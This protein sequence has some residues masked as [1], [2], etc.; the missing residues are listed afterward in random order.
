M[1]LNKNSFLFTLLL[2]QSLT[3]KGALEN[4]KKFLITQVED[5]KKW[6]DLPGG[7]YT[8]GFIENKE[9]KELTPA[10]IY[11]KTFI[12][13]HSIQFWIRLLA[14]TVGI[15]DLNAANSIKEIK[16]KKKKKKEI[17]LS[18]DWWK[19]PNI[20]WQS[21]DG[22]CPYKEAPHKVSL[23][24]IISLPKNIDVI[25]KHNKDI[26][27]YLKIKNLSKKIP[28]F[29]EDHIFLKK[30]YL[31]QD[32]DGSYLLK[33]YT[34]KKEKPV[35]V[36]DL[37]AYDS[38]LHYAM[39]WAISTNVLKASLSFIPIFGMTQVIIAILERAFNFIETLYLMRHA[40]TLELI[41]QALSDN[42]SSP[43]YNKLNKEEMIRAITYL[44]RSNSMLS[45][46]IL[47]KLNKKDLVNKFLE[48][49]EK[50][51]AKSI[52]YLNSKKIS[53]TPLKGTGFALGIKN[54]PNKKTAATSIK[55]KFKM[56]SLTKLQGLRKKPYSLV[57]YLNTNKEIRKRNA[58]EAGLIG[59]SLLFLPIP[60]LQSIIKISY[61]EGIIRKIHK[62]Q[63]QEE[64]L[65]A[66]ILNDPSV[67]KDLFSKQGFNEAETTYY[68]EKTLQQLE[69]RKM[70]P[71][72]LSF[73]EEHKNRRKVERWIMSKDPSY[74]P[75]KNSNI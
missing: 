1:P 39:N 44:L 68:Y 69:R 74:I 72:D 61:K 46:I 37:L 49:R 42:K 66:T 53:V 11:D 43:F 9:T 67:F 20:K 16:K 25:N 73:E 26:H 5:I 22:L 51:Y 50:S 45:G 10:A 28:F 63:M 71:L 15:N 70:N 21:P 41:V 75:W 33:F 35:K 23:S 7:R 54:N 12:S 24:K 58:L 47:S 55:K 4:G 57:N 48:K 59:T 31:I 32:L 18:Q 64:S 6:E 40:A 13:S 52:Y 56:Y 2:I 30:T 62:H 17:R 27:K 8:I 34:S 3:L 14:A 60:G 19:N 29:Q 38:S 36:V 65:K